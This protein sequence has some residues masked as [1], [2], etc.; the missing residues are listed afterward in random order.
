MLSFRFYIESIAFLRDKTT[1]ELFF[2][3][4][5]ACVHRVRPPVRA[6][7]CPPVGASYLPHALPPSGSWLVLPKSP[8][9]G[10]P[11]RAIRLT[12]TSVS[13]AARAAQGMPREAL[14][15]ETS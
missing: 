1:V 12:P 3:N 9:V 5:K 4:A 11:C 14:L 7:P 10:T 8:G 15:M 13:R 2:L 6:V